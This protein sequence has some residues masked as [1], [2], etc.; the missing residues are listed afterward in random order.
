MIPS[1]RLVNILRRCRLPHA[2]AATVG[3][4]GKGGDTFQ[5]NMAG[6]KVMHGFRKGESR[7]LATSLPIQL[8]AG[9]NALAA[10]GLADVGDRGGHM[11]RAVKL[12]I[13]TEGVVRYRIIAGVDKAGT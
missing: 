1:Y 11:Q 4:E 2:T 9:A 3:Q 12:L 8:E 5:P 13:G 10:S 6:G 7:Y